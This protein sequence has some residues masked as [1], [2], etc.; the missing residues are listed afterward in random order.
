MLKM[1]LPSTV[2]ISIGT[3]VTV[4]TDSG[5][6]FVPTTREIS[7]QLAT[8]LH[9]LEKMDIKIYLNKNDG[10]IRVK[11]RYPP[12]HSE[13]GIVYEWFVSQAEVEWKY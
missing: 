10:N 12:A 5:T 3:L 9:E 2:I 7:L 4:I 13:Y 8:T 6:H 11:Y 1:T